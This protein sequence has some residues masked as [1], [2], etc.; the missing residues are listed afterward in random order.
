MNPMK[1]LEDITGLRQLPHGAVVSIGN[2]DGVHRGHQRLLQ[3][4]HELKASSHAPA[5]RLVTFEP[6]PPTVLRP[7]QAPPRLTT[8]ERKRELL[9]DAGLDVL[10]VLPP[11]SEVL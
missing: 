5:T 10:V 11:S 8:P 1:I 2:F 6:H 4:A 7:K 3:A 9:N